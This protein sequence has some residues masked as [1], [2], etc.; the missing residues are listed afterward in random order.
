MNDLSVATAPRL[1]PVDR[2]Y[3]TSFVVDQSPEEVFAAI[4]NVR[5]WWTGDIT[6]S[7]DRLGEEFTYRYADIHRSTQRIT[8]LVPGRKVVWLVTD[9]YLSFVAD[10][11]E[12]T[13]TTMVF[14]IASK[15]GKTELRFTHIGLLA[16]NECY[17][18][19][20]SAWGSLI[21]TSLRN[22]ITTGKSGL[23]RL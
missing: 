23:D 3:T 6:G 7:T 17:D 11:A 13:G 15:A 2:S 14:D 4:N 10:K 8:E 1:V 18:S 9:G 21:D 5:A 22:L 20:S 12:W 16:G 19:C